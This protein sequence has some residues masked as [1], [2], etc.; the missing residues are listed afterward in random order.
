VVD[1]PYDPTLKTLVET[2]PPDWLPLLALPPAPV[3]VIDADIATVISGAADKVLLVQGDLSYLL[4]LDFEAG[5]YSARVPGRLRLYNTVLD[6][7]HDL[8]VRSVLVLLHPR[9]DSP[10]LT[11]ELR[12][13]FPNEPPYGLFRYRVLRVWQLPV[14]Q[15]LTGGIGTLALAPISD[16]PE[17]ELPRVIEQMEQR[18]RRRPERELARDVW[19]ATYL[20]L[21][22]RY[23]LELARILLQ[24]VLR[25]KESVTY[26]AVVEEGRIEEA[27]RALLLV[28]KELL[29]KPDAA[30]KGA[31]NAL[32]D[33][34]QLEEL[35]RRAAHVGSWQELLGRPTPRRRG[36]R[37]T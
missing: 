26:Q 24:R 6:Y 35:M 20:L 27:R 23:D 15:L 36:R 34:A 16:V 4:H 19:T 10:Q 1:K 8:L 17:A 2:S 11:G 7:R 31:I 14:E 37:Q 32:E 21:G 3:V 22:L 9:A 33:V 28:G 29:G 5:H 18:L 25:M 30:T 12:R 13:A